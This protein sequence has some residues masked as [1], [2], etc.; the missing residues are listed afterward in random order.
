[1]GVKTINVKEA[2]NLRE[3][4]IWVVLERGKARDK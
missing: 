1:M 4:S 2:V 3:R